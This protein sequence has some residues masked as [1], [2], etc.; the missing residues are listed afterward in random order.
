MAEVLNISTISRKQV[1]DLTGQIEAVIRREKM[2]E[3]LC[4]LFVAHTT[5]AAGCR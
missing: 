3:G 5:A 4:A 2:L 1:V